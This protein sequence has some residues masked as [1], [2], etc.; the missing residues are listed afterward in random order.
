LA[1]AELARLL[2][3]ANRD[4][5]CLDRK[6]LLALPLTLQRRVVRSALRRITAQRQGPSC[7]AVSQVLDRV[8]H[9]TSGSMANI[10]GAA[11][12]REY[13]HIR[14]ALPSSESRVRNT[15]EMDR[16]RVALPVP[17]TV[18]WPPTGQ[19]VA[20]NLVHSWVSPARDGSFESSALVDPDRLTLN[21]EVRS[22]SP[23]D[24][25]QPFGMHGRRKKLQDFF[26]D[27]KVPRK[28]RRRIPVIVAPEGIVW[29]AGHRI[30]HRFRI[31]S[32]T[33]RMLCLRLI[34]ADR[35]GRMD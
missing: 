28:G 31:T 27:L 8:V 33:S 22:W 12:T 17:S 2:R 6:G 24:A 35:S 23:G 3:P 26:A 16:C 30:D 7:A 15:L 20:A 14:F 32:H 29:I 21:L 9:G 1:E 11:V 13:E 34:D 25:F 19:R 18:T 4:E 10:R 5:C